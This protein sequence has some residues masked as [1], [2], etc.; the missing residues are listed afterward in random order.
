ME[1]NINETTVKGVRRAVGSGK[2]YR[3]STIAKGDVSYD[4]LPD[5]Y[6]LPFLPDILGQKS[7]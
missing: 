5:S 1:N 4:S 3:Y 6:M 7:V 2:I